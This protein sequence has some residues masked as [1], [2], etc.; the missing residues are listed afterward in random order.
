MLAVIMWFW[1]FAAEDFLICEVYDCHSGDEDSVFW[2]DKRCRLVYSHLIIYLLTQ[3][4]HIRRHES[5]VLNYVCLINSAT[6]RDTELPYSS[7]G[8]VSTSIYVFVVL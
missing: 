8:L 4:L 3:H 7:C 1:W 5:S 2:Y 6:V